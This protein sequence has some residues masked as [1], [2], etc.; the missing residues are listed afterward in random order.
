MKCIVHLGN[1]ITENSRSNTNIV[2]C[3]EETS[4]ARRNLYPYYIIVSVYL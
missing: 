1:S 3:T 2:H 4:L